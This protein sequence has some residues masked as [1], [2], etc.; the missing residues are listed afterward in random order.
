MVINKH[1]DFPNNFGDQ[2]LISRK[3]VFSL[4]QRKLY[5]YV[6]L[7]KHSIV[8][9]NVFKTD[10]KAWKEKKGYNYLENQNKENINKIRTETFH[11]IL[12]SAA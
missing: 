9:K 2:N 5:K 12:L 6:N 1:K 10:K 3:A 7:R 4:T 11:R 8:G